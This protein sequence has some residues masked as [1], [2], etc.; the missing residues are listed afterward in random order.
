LEHD[1]AAH[2]RVD[3]LIERE[4]PDRLHDDSN[5]LVGNV[6]CPWSGILADQRWEAK[7]RRFD[8]PRI[9]DLNLRD[10]LVP[11]ALLATA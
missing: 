2:A 3:E 8:V 1:F 6:K 5:G 11:D 7:V 10:P 9:E 4:K